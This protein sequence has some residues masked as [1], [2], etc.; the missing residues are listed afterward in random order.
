MANH[1]CSVCGLE[2]SKSEFRW[3]TRS[4]VRGECKECEKTVLRCAKCNE[5]KPHDDFPPCKKTSTGRH[6]WC[7]ECHRKK[8]LAYWDSPEFRERR[9]EYDRREEVVKNRRV[10][11][12]GGKFKAIQ[13]RFRAT[14][15]GKFLLN[16]HNIKRQQLLKSVECTLTYAE[17]VGILAGQQNKCIYCEREFDLFLKPERDHRIPLSKGGTHTKDNVVAACRHC[18]SS[19]KDGD[20]PKSLPPE[21]V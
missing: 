18:N 20:E 9:A 10:Y 11:Q 19:K 8:Q 7:L 13:Q 3:N 4:G 2:K 1:K 12:K 15:K 6:G 14:A 16:K 17:W 21:V 5:V